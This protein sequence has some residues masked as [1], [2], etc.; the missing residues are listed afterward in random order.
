M[1]THQ[2]VSRKSVSQGQTQDVSV[3]LTKSGEMSVKE[4]GAEL[5]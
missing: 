1:S 5:H 3:D 4:R 2:R